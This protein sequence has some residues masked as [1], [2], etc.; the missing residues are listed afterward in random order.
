M[1]HPLERPISME[2]EGLEICG[3]DF[4]GVESLNYVVNKALFVSTGYQGPGKFGL[5]C[6]PVQTYRVGKRK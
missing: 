6:S 1:R 3:Q 5:G 4:A 2:E